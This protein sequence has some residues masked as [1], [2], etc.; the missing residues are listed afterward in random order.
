[1]IWQ[2]DKVILSGA[3]AKDPEG[4][5]QSEFAF[6]WAYFEGSGND[7]VLNDL[8]WTSF[9]G[10]RGEPTIDFTFDSPGD[11]RII[12]EVDDA[13][14]QQRYESGTEPVNL[15]ANEIAKFSW[16]DDINI[17]VL[18]FA[19]QTK[20]I[21]ISDLDNNVVEVRYDIAYQ[22]LSLTTD[23]TQGIVNVTK[24]NEPE[25][26]ETNRGLRTFIDF[27]TKKMYNKEGKSGFVWADI[28]I[29]YDKNQLPEQLKFEEANV[30]NPKEPK[31]PKDHVVLMYYWDKIF[32][33][34]V[35]CDNTM[36]ATENDVR[37]L[38]AV[39]CN[40]THFTTLAPLIN[41]EIENFLRDPSI[42]PMDIDFSTNPILGRGDSERDVTI[43]AKIR[44]LG[45]LPVND[46]VVKFKDGDVV[47]GTTTVTTIPGYGSSIAT[48]KWTIKKDID[49]GTHTIKVE[50][51][52]NNKIVDNDDSNDIAR[53]KV[54]VVEA[55]GV[56]PSYNSSL[57]S[58]V[59]AVI[60]VTLL[61]ITTRKRK[62]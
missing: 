12:L 47:I 24:A 7:M 3:G 41:D 18:P 56:V 53:K 5:S 30:Y 15:S 19:K 61:G 48:I 59:G 43:T 51:D 40:V 52:P 1:M 39:E 27:Q 28:V 31:K 25:D 9:K 26:S 58:V 17:T 62:K 13:Y 54:Q 46:V 32:N 42:D 6:R 2:G 29:I 34:W 10:G 55:I 50:L 37:D 21:F 16:L 33:A 49:I 14:N 36:K 35:K 23:D 8:E 38:T 44:N 11:Y 60:A 45:L 20:T 4:R 57:V 22:A